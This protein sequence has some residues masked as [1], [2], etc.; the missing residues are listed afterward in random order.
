[1]SLSH[2]LLNLYLEL[3]DKA[4]HLQQMVEPV[5]FALSLK[6]PGLDTKKTLQIQDVLR[7]RRELRA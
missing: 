6:N 3:N 4:V 5:C 2:L 7:E 1:M